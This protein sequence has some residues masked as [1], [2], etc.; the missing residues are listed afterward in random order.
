MS[1]EDD[2]DELSSDLA[3]LYAQLSNPHV[4]KE[5]LGSI[6]SRL[7]LQFRALAIIVLLGDGSTDWFL[8][9]LMRSARARLTYL[10]RHQ[11]LGIVDPYYTAAGRYEP[12]LD[13]IAAADY[14][15][16]RKIGAL[17]TIT[18]CPGEYEDDHHYGRIL[19]A[20][21]AYQ[22]P[23]DVLTDQV[24]QL[25]LYQDGEESIRLDLVRALIAADQDLFDEAFE[26]LLLEFEDH[27]AFLEA[28]GPLDEAAT[29][30][31][32]LVCIEGLAI[33]RLAEFRGLATDTE[34]RFCPSLARR[35]MRVPFQPA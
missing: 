26:E 35:P 18:L 12:L 21:I 4:P 28:Q 2:I 11:A 3:L 14:D 23:S 8:H 34:Y 20:L 33:L 30:A 1:V 29:T 9:M 22:I 32:R 13:A 6:C 19:H 5:Q 24:N 15:V 7:S 17:S 31:L 16:A 10:E 25:T 27:V